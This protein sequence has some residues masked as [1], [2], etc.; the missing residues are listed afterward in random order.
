MSDTT[1]KSIRSQILKVLEF[2]GDETPDM[3]PTE[4]AMG[5]IALD[6]YFMKEDG[7]TDVEIATRLASISAQ[8]VMSY[9]ATC[10]ANVKKESVH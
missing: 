7:K 10:D 6:M 5:L 2:I 3:T 9:S 8:I 4:I 1:A